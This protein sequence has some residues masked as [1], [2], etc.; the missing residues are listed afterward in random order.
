MWRRGE[1]GGRRRGR[2]RSASACRVSQPNKS[3]SQ[4]RTTSLSLR[5]STVNARFSQRCRL[6]WPSRRYYANE[7]DFTDSWIY[8]VAA[9]VAGYICKTHVSDT[10]TPKYDTVPIK[11]SNIQLPPR[12][13]AQRERDRAR[14]R[15]ATARSVGISALRRP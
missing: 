9:A 2:E 6:G 1:K 4:V 15:I 10:S 7:N 8:R 14:L 13:S 3:V 12:K 5:R 11:R